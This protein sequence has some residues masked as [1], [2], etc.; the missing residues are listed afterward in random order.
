[1]TLS[2]E[3]AKLKNLHLTTTSS[4]CSSEGCKSIAQK[5]G[6]CIRHGAKV[7]RCNSGGCTNQGGVCRRHGAELKSCRCNSKGSQ[8]FP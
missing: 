4:S 6:V 1:M 5:G 8:I 2:A 3:E 7:K